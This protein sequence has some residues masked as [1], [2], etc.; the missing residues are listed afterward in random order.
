LEGQ[1]GEKCASVMFY[2]LNPKDKGRSVREI[3]VGLCANRTGEYP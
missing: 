1:I 3:I 2:G